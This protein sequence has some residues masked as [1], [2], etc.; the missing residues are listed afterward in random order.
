LIPAGGLL[1]ED[2]LL[3]SLMTLVRLFAA[4]VLGWTLV[5]L[6]IGAMGGGPPSPSASVALRVGPT[7]HDALSDVTPG[8]ERHDLVD[9]VTGRSTPI[10]LPER[11][12][13]TIMSVCPWR[14]S[15][16]ELE[17]VGRWVSRGEGEFCGMG[18]FRLSD[19]AVL[20]RVAME[21]LPTGR[22]CWIPGQPRT[23]LFPAGDG[24]LHRCRL[25]AAA[26]EGGSSLAAEG[27]LGRASPVPVTWN[28]PLPGL[29][30]VY[31]T[32]PVWSSD[33]RLRKWVI[34]AL[35]QQ[36]R[37]GR[38]AAFQPSK[39]WWLEMS[40][41]AESI[42]SAGRLTNPAGAG[43]DDDDLQEQYP[44]VAVGPEGKVHLV[45]LAR[46][47]GEKSARIRSADLSFDAETGRPHLASGR[48][49]C[50]TLGEGLGTAPLL[51]SADGTKVFGLDGSGRLSPFAL[52]G[53]S[54]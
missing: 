30:G 52:E 9:L 47:R 4:L 13:W 33:P 38:H 12:R 23:I 5:A 34:V 51:V 24:R 2:T 43:A 32:D 27:G 26:V 40:D 14:D 29:G 44:N 15:R 39:L 10:P 11:D 16:G 18:S 31:L 46:R 20:S 7:L 19:A 42:L 37:R 21:I 17:V 45:Y 28:V 8:S 48:G 35:S 1:V 50:R 3:M 25:P 6:G 49:G 36:E 54:D 53:K 41:Q 22:P